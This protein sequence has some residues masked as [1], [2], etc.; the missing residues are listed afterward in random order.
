MKKIIILLLGFW[1]S[2]IIAQSCVNISTVGFTSC[3]NEVVEFNAEFSED[4]T[5]NF[6]FT[7]NTCGATFA[8]S[9]STT[10]FTTV[11][12]GVYTLRVNSGKT[13][14]YYTVKAIVGNSLNV[15]SCSASR[16]TNVCQLSAKKRNWF[17]RTYKRGND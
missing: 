17:L 15:G 14:G 4:T 8:E 10:Y 3:E 5:V 7:Q 13:D 1:Y 16:S 12:K 2:S 9:E 6:V 11:S